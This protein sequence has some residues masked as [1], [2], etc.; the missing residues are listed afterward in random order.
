[1]ILPDFSKLKVPKNE[2]YVPIKR[3][4]AEFLFNFLKKKKIKSTLEIGFAYGFSTAYIISATKSE[5]FV[6]DPNQ[7]SI[8]KKH[9]VK[10]IKAL[11]LSKYLH[12][13][14]DKSYNALPC[15]LKKNL[16]FDFI[17]IDGDHKFD[18]IFLDF[19]YSD[20]LLNTGGYI[21]FHDSWMRPIQL[22]TAWIINNKKNYKFVKCSEK[23]LIVLKK[24]K[25][26]IDRPWYHF[27][28]FYTFKSLI[29]HLYFRVFNRPPY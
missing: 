4:E 24:T 12:P 16:R 15:I 13:I 14:E 27:N 17:F 3:S 1:M 7:T 6:I 5:H 10:N 18:N 11:S 19:Y 25:D 26:D 2:S 21:I 9:G 20:L 28:E 23:N 29:L 22:T 8:Y